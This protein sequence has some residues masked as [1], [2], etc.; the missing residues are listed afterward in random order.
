[1]KMKKFTFFDGFTVAIGLS[2]MFNSHMFLL[3]GA[4]LDGL[5]PSIL[6]ENIFGIAGVSIAY[7]NTRR[8][9]SDLST[10]NSFFPAIENT[11]GPIWIQKEQ[12][13]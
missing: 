7:F 8:K 12:T 3:K 4:K 9:G 11:T 6:N 13:D 1:M 2:L 10:L 5:I